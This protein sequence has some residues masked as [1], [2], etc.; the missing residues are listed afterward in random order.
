MSTVVNRMFWI[1][2]MLPAFEPESGTKG[3]TVSAL[4]GSLL[5]GSPCF[6]TTK[7]AGRS[8]QLSITT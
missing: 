1:L 6:G 5:K 4:L 8:C 7:G 2:Q 3:P